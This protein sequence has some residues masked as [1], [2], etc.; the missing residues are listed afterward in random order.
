MRQ[1]VVASMALAGLIACSGDSNHNGS[2]QTGAALGDSGPVFSAAVTMPAY[3]LLDAPKDLD[4]VIVSIDTLRADRLPFYG[5]KHATGGSA[6]TPWSL[7]W[8]AQQGTV[9]EQV[10]AP[11]G[12]TLPAFGSFWTGLAPLEHGTTT[13]HGKVR[14]KN[15]ALQLAEQG[16]V[17]HAVVS[18]GV[19]N[20]SCGLRRGFQSYQLSTNEQEDQASAKLLAYTGK[21][22]KRGQR[23]SLMWAHYMAPHQPYT[24]KAEFVG[25]FSKA[26][27]VAGDRET[28][29]R[30]FADPQAF[31]AAAREHL[32][33]LYDE[34]ILTAN[35][36]VVE[37]LSGLDRQYQDAGRGGLLDNAIVV[38]M[39]DHGEELADH[40]SY[41]MHA[42]SLYR[43]VTQVPL[44]VLGGGWPQGQRQAV[45]LALA[46]ILPM[47]VFGERPQPGYSFSSW[48]SRFF[49]ARDARWTLVHN[50]SGDPLGPEAPPLDVPFRYPQVALYD[51]QQDPLEQHDVATVHPEVTRRMLDAMKA[52]Y[53]DLAIDGEAPVVE[54][55]ED[56]REQL[57]ALGYATGSSDG[58][59]DLDRPWSGQRW[60][61]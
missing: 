3:G 57:E 12:L 29:E 50:P 13:N 52:W 56:Q 53:D 42:K 51:R 34:E 39:S 6:D 49:V 17:N 28:L 33:G 36:Y 37:F 20:P 35:D 59:T 18:N 21:T 25:T 43:G 32:R 5:A 61:P 45:S 55:S 48:G 23:R 9:L 2:A 8:L 44:I 58:A 16:W 30:L 40:Q 41:F 60:K 10:W 54:L 27:D 15:F 31:D 4:L 47:V 38:V 22:V 19:L 11:A 1:A 46:D 14:A 26:L 24:P 7:S